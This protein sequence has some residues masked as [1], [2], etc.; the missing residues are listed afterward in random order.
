MP[1]PD[2]VIVGAGVIGAS[3]ASH[4]AMR[5]L[6]VTVIERGTAPAAGST[7]RATGGFRSQFSTAVNVQLSLLSREKLRRF[8]E[9]IGVDSG[10]RE[11]GY[12]FVASSEQEMQV[13]E[14][15]NTVQQANGLREARLLSRGEI[16]DINPAISRDVPVAGGAWCPT[17]G[18]LR[19][20]AITNGYVTAAARLGAEFRFGVEVTGG[21][22]AGER[23]TALIT[24]DGR[25][26]GQIFVNAAGAWAR[27]LMQ[28]LGDDLPVEPLQ[29]H[30]A[31]T[32]PTAILPESMPMTVFLSD[33]FHLRVRDGRI[34]LLRPA[35]PASNDPFDQTFDDSWLRETLHIAHARIPLLRDCEV[36]RSACWSGLY[37]MSPD[38]HAIVGRAPRFDNLFLANGSSGHGVMHAPAL[39]EV[40]A[41]M[42]VNGKARLPGVEALRPSRFDEGAAIA[43]S[44][45]L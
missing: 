32:V 38:R 31:T 35:P 5:G 24:S 30:V 40:V 28:R 25:H 6:A 33:G 41:E 44:H 18:F 22:R 14:N 39:G 8:E 15:A 12:L 19:A 13:L 36:D 10:Y 11:Y 43:S 37:E 29:R 23:L 27:L 3:I 16:F 1:S 34:L 7:S 4:L 17:D 9:E 21:Q 20:T 26:E 2:V 45:L 42:I